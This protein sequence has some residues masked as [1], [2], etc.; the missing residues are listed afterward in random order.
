MYLRILKNS[1]PSYWIRHFELHIFY[2]RFEINE[3]KTLH[4]MLSNL[5]GYFSDSKGYRA[6]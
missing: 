5:N 1:C 4:T 3:Y 2:N 6:L